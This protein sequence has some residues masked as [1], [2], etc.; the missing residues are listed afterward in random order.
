[1]D[2]IETLA[3]Q[4]GQQADEAGVTVGVAESLTGGLVV[5]A[6]ACADGASQWLR[7]GV[8]AYSASV[9]HRLLQVKI[10]DVVSQQAAI[11]MAAGA[12]KVLVTF[13]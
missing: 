11:A 4:I 7:G 8:V 10:D 1:M 2:G 3:E 13:H 5:Q 6:L 12:R 9:K